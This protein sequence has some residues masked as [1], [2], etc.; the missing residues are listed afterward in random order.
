MPALPPLWKREFQKAVQES[1]DRAAHQ[2]DRQ[3]EEN[4]A[5]IA[6]PLHD[7]VEEFKAYHEK[8]D[9]SEEESATR[10][11][12][13]IAA[14]ILTV[15]FT[16]ITVIIFHGQLDEMKKAYLPVKNQAIAAIAAAQAA[17]AAVELSD[18]T[19]ERQLRAYVNVEGSSLTWK[20]GARASAIITIRNAG[21]TPAKNVSVRGLV[22]TNEDAP[23]NRLPAYFGDTPSNFGMVADTSKATK[24]IG[25]AREETYTIFSTYIVEKG[26]IRKPA[27]LPGRIFI[28]GAVYYNDIFGIQRRTRFCIYYLALIESNY[29]AEHNDA[30]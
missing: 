16:F 26:T 8:Q 7:L 17:K 14:L 2:R 30:N 12:I 23:P 29:C 11:R 5:A 22:A 27:H 25:Q 19:A 13:T 9:R 10:E 28:I 24:I 15:V 1:A 21:Q 3:D 18:K 4:S 6:R 20:S